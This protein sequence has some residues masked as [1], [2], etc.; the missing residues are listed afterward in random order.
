MGLGVVEQV[1]HLPLRRLFDSGVPIAL[2]TDDPLLFGPRLVEQYRIAREVFGFTDPELAELARMSIRAS[3]APDP[4]KKELS[5]GVDAWLA[6]PP[7]P[8]EG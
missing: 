4:L 6:A 3:G 1:E 5:A 2:G 7:E 8:L